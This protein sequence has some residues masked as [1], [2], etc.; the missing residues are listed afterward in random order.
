MFEQN[1][2]LFIVL[3]VVTVEVWNGLKA[4]YSA[5]RQIRGERWEDWK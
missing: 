3:V 4:F 1:P 2:W 5:A